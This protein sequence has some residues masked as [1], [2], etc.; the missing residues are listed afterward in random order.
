MTTCC[1]CGKPTPDQELPDGIRGKAICDDCAKP[2]FI[3]VVRVS[4]ART[5]YHTD[6]TGD[7]D[8]EFCT[9]VWTTKLEEVE[10]SQNLRAEIDKHNDG[11]EDFSSWVLF[12]LDAE[13]RRI[14]IDYT[15]DGREPSPLDYI[16]D[17]CQKERFIEFC[18]GRA[19][20]RE[21]QQEYGLRILE[22]RIG[23]LKEPEEESE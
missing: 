8:R 13:T 3:L 22:A 2:K 5:E 12:V 21:N 16:T 18:R 10:V 1:R 17:D 14:L 6:E 20:S 11:D 15:D 4:T 19:K 23:E 7:Y 9:Q